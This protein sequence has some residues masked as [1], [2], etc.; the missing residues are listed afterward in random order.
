MLIF[1][2]L[3]H[4]PKSRP[5]EGIIPWRILITQMIYFVLNSSYN[6]LKS[7]TVWLTNVNTLDSVI[8]LLI[9]TK[10]LKIFFLAYIMLT[11]TPFSASKIWIRSRF[12]AQQVCARGTPCSDIATSSPPKWRAGVRPPVP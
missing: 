7:A 9:T 4:N 2:K 6:N 5:S 8:I 3:S 10:L 1:G 11:W 12:S